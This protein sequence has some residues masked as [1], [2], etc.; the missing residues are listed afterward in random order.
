MRN[1]TRRYGPK[2]AAKRLRSRFRAQ[3]TSVSFS[4]IKCAE[5]SV[6]QGLSSVFHMSS[7]YKHCSSWLLLPGSSWLL[8]APPSSSWLLLAPAGSSWPSWLLLASQDKGKE[9]QEGLRG[10]RGDQPRFVEAFWASFRLSLS[11]LATEHSFLIRQRIQTRISGNP[12][13][14]I[15]VPD[16]G[17]QQG[18]PRPWN[19]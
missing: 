15:G 12:K 18:N 6:H 13:G 10:A 17:L 11:G 19:N 3:Y 4:G 2:L 9:A 16:P 8:L 5:L 7:P 1:Q 14:T